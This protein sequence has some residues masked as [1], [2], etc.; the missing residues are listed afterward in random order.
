MRVSAGVDPAT[1]KYRRISR[2]FEGTYRE[3][4]REL[5]AMTAT[6]KVTRTT[7][8]TFGELLRQWV[9]SQRVAP[10]TKAKM[11]GQATALCRHLEHA[12]M[13][14]LSREQIQ[15]ALD[16]LAAGD[17]PSGR[18]CTAT[19]LSGCRSM[20]MAF[21]RWCE[22][23]HRI[24]SAAILATDT[25]TPS[26]ER[27]KALTEPQIG[28]ILDMCRSE[29]AYHTCIMLALLAGLRRGE[30]CRCLEWSDVDWQ[31]GTMHVPGTKTKASDAVVPLAPMLADFLRDRRAKMPD[32][33]YVVDLD[34]H[35]MSQWWRRHRD[36]LGLEGTTFHALRH[37]Y[38]TELAR[39]GVHPSVMQALARH[40]DSRMTMDV[41]TH[42]V[43][44]QQRAAT[45][46][47]QQRMA[48][49]KNKTK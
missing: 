22:E 29:S 5:A 8:D 46:A 41:Y 48:K 36:E 30:C 21:L 11:R 47:F 35:S 16:R 43:L 12:R 18:P 32:V 19:Y 20:L 15:L 42:V 2:T 40:S 3:A 24:E 31:E 17:S 4:Q 14:T 38:V 27:R 26:T 45:D 9:E 25:I 28:R 37:T 33:L 44:D 10:S 7:R 49:T 1:G 34:A 39:A 13:G 6:E 23:G